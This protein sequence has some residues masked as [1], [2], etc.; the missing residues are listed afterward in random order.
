MALFFQ[1]F[2]TLV[3]NMAAAA[4]ASAKKVLDFTE[5]SVLRALLEAQAGVQLWLQA[6]VAAVF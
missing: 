4:Q 3:Q 1:T 2:T 6:L 5:G